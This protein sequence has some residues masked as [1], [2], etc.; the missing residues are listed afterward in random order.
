MPQNHGGFQR[1]SCRLSLSRLASE[2]LGFFL[3][4]TGML[5]LVRVNGQI[6][7]KVVALRVAGARQGE[8]T[9]D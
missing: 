2:F 4:L 8:P 5:Y 3:N 9:S 7:I 6:E 1:R